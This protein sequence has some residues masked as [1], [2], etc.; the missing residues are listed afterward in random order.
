MMMKIPKDLQTISTTVLF[1]KT[2]FV[3][4]LCL[5]VICITSMVATLLSGSNKSLPNF[6]D[7]MIRSELLLAI[8]IAAYLTIVVNRWDRVRSTL[9]ANILITFE[10]LHHRLCSVL[11]KTQEKNEDKIINQTIRY[12]RLILQLLFLA[13]QGNYVSS[14]TSL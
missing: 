9:L 12:T 6:T 7:I 5:S 13:V 1:D 10:D 14:C 3:N 11:L 8:S 4:V 2:L